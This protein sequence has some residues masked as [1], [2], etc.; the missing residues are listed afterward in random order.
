MLRAVLAVVL[1]VALLGVAMPAVD[2]AR[3]DRTSHLAAGELSRLSERT[4]GLA[5]TEEVGPDATARRVVSLS[6]PGAGF[7]TAPLEYVAVGG[8]PDCGRPRDTA[9]GDV[10]AYR[11]RGG[12]PQVRHVPVD[13]RVVTGGRVRGDEDPL[14]LRG[15]AHLTLSLV[16]RGGERTVLVRRGRTSEPVDP[17][18]SRGGPGA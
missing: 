1:A 9:E 15:D 12:A 18:R 5:A 2:E 7:T 4:T 17:D 10:V 14:V 13:L 16:S 11:L 6:V 8:V 3:A